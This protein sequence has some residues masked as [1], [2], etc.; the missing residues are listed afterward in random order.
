MAGAEVKIK[1]RIKHGG[2]AG[3][4][5]AVLTLLQTLFPFFGFSPVTFLGFWMHGRAEALGEPGPELFGPSGLYIVLNVGSLLLVVGLTIG[6]FKRN[7]WCA[8]ALFAY[9]VVS[10]LACI[11]IAVGL[12][13][14]PLLAL[15]VILVFLFRSMMATF[16]YHA[17]LHQTS[18]LPRL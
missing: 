8:L 18:S 15:G 7:R 9:C 11:P 13:G 17:S 2:I 4:V 10:F 6:L 16:D 12:F 1:Q 14:L 5:L 3:S